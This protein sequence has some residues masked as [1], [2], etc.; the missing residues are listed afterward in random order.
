[1]KTADSIAVE[2]INDVVLD[3]ENVLENVKYRFLNKDSHKDFDLEA[4][5]FCDLKVGYEVELYRMQGQS[6]SAIIG[7][8]LLG[9]IGVTADELEQAAFANTRKED[10]IIRTLGD[11][12]EQLTGME[13]P[14]LCPDVPPIYVISNKSNFKGAVAMLIPEIMQTVSR[15]LGGDFYILP[16]SMHEVMAV[17]ADQEKLDDYREMVTT[18]NKTAVSMDDKLSDTVY[19]YDS[20]NEEIV[21]AEREV[22]YA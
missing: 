16:S 12:M 14:G 17:P 19:R 5:H 20:G 2:S 7:S 11:M 10:F 9:K 8:S 6:A 22:A 13:D 15:K 3:R 21:V 18:I 4:K 1:M